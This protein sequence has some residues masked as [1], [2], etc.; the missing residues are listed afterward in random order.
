MKVITT[1]RAVFDTGA[2][3]TP[4]DLNAIWL[5][6]KDVVADVGERRFAEGLL[7][8]QS[9]EAV[10]TPYTQAMNI[11]ERTW[12]FICPV[13]CVIQRGYFHANM[14]ST[15]EVT[16]K[17]TDTG[18]NTP[19]GC[20]V[21][22]L[23]TKDAVN[24]STGEVIDADTG[25]VTDESDDIQSIN[26][27]RVMLDAGTEY[28]IKIEGSANF[29]LNRFDIVLHTLT[30]RWTPSGTTSVPA[31]SPTL[32]R[33][34]DGAAAAGVNSNNTA[35][36]VQA[37]AFGFYKRAPVPAV[38]TSYA[39]VAATTINLRKFR[40]PRFYTARAQSKIIE[41]DLF[42]YTA[43]ATTIT[44][45]VRDEAGVVVRTVTAAVV[46]TQLSVRDS[47][48]SINLAGS[49]GASDTP[50]QDYTIE[51]ANSSATNCIKAYALVW[52][53]RD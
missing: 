18:G 30:D 40:I 45:V 1:Q 16:V 37:D 39:F 38:F 53:S 10:D 11:E 44:A 5:Y 27:D 17:I 52:F 29:T 33:E 2:I 14:T 20:T 22:W 46:G 24:V 4:D 7:V 26:V 28:L 3:V 13:T 9:V 36:T 19:S 42:A 49:G 43:G 23:T 12:R 41:I 8:L 48:L 6:G 47:G 21:P 32:Y 35:L 31:F 51:F 25:V 15:G 50:A 34:G